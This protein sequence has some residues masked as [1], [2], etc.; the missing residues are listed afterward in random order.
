MSCSLHDVEHAVV[1]MKQQNISL[2]DNM[3]ASHK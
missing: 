3:A 1:N 2:Y